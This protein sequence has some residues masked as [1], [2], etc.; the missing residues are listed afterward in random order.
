MECHNK[1]FFFSINNNIQ[2]SPFFCTVLVC[3][4]NSHSFLFN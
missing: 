4:P 2:T 1:F 3:L